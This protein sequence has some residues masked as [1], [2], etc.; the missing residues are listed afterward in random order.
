MTPGKQ[1]AYQR[2][3]KLVGT[4]FGCM[5][6]AF[7]RLPRRLLGTAMLVA[8]LL[9]AIGAA[10]ALSHPE[11]SSHSAASDDARVFTK[12][13]A[14]DAPDGSGL[15]AAGDEAE[16]DCLV[17]A[18]GSI[19]AY[20]HLPPGACPPLKKLGRLPLPGAGALRTAVLRG[21]PPVP[22]QPA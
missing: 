14:F 2:D 15:P 3:G 21:D 13:I 9:L 17:P 6:F 7:L 1:A 8:A 4:G 20:L 18:C 11:A 19:S 5:V 16:G 10:E 22:R 12:P